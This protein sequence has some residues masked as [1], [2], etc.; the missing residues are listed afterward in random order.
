MNGR[1]GIGPIRHRAIMPRA[2]ASSAERQRGFAN[3]P[4]VLVARAARRLARLGGC[5]STGS[6]GPWRSSRCRSSSGIPR[7]LFESI[8]GLGSRR[9]SRL[10]R[11]SWIEDEFAGSGE[12]ARRGLPRMRVWPA[13][14][15]TRRGADSG[16]RRGV[17]VENRR[18]STPGEPR[19]AD[20]GPPRS[21][22][23]AGWPRGSPACLDACS[24]LARLSSSC[25]V[26]PGSTSTS[27]S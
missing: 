8:D 19:G 25:L 5:L 1:V 11:P 24:R 12:A 3:A 23:T 17:W 4:G 10:A 7:Y 21:W 22:R 16:G 14:R 2:T 9:G 20:A 27:S 26:I 15:R 6:V 13:T 18:S